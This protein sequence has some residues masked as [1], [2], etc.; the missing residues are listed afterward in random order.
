LKIA[1]DDL[2]NSNDDE[3]EFEKICQKYNIDPFDLYQFREKLK[4]KHNVQQDPEITRVDQ[5]CIKQDIIID[6]LTQIR[7][8]LKPNVQLK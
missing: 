3:A 8:L 6:L 1:N 2:Q 7:D 5:A 4:N